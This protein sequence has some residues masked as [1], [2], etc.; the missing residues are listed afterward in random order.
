MIVVIDL[1]ALISAQAETPVVAKE[2]K[3]TEMFVFFRCLTV[4]S[5]ITFIRLLRF[6]V[7]H[8]IKLNQNIDH[9]QMS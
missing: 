1:V 4:L 9:E 7:T 5:D 8:W 6:S 2:T 3:M